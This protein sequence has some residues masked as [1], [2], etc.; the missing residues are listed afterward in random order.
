MK[1]HCGMY[2]KGGSKM[3]KILRLCAL[4]TLILCIG[5]LSS[6]SCKPNGPYVAI[7]V[8]GGRHANLATFDYSI[9]TS[10]I[11][12][13]D[14][15][16][17]SLTFSE[18]DRVCKLVGIVGDEN[19]N[20]NSSEK[21][22]TFLEDFDKA[23]KNERW[24][25]TQQRVQPFIE[26]IQDLPANDPE[27]D[28]LEALHK[29]AIEFENLENT[30]KKIIICDSGLSTTG[31]LSFINYDYKNLIM[32]EGDVTDDEITKLI[33]ELKLKKEIPDLSGFQIYWYG[34]G[35]VDGAQPRLTKQAISNLTAVWR[36]ILNSASAE[37]QFL[38]V[39]PIDDSEP[40]EPLPPVSAV[41]TD[42]V[43]LSES[44]LGFKP[45]LAEFIEETEE[46]R[47]KCL[48]AFVADAKNNK[49]LLVGTTSSG[50]GS[51]DGI[52]LSNQRVAA[53]KK[54]LIEL[55]VPEKNINTIALGTRHHKYNPNEFIN[56]KYIS[57]SIAA[58]E[59]RSV[60]IMPENCKEALKFQEDYHKLNNK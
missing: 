1:K 46:S 21:I 40:P 12:N 41:L 7:A 15:P 8:I 30:E 25:T 22:I 23:V 4:V 56:G 57:D 39:N 38:S 2:K 32:R 18:E 49:I 60:Y 27:V 6:C 54:E 31:A 26:L 50:G 13:A 20:T 3:K 24:D 14:N 16:S 44:E 10:K 59:N 5:L 35:L 34:I 48:S 45:G 51:G 11:P 55:G 53:V 19:P 42:D 28:T 17:H 36:T 9:I 37:V 43:S 33:E 58:I 29:T 52:E 47:R